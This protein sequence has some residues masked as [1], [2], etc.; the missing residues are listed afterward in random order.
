MMSAPL[1]IMIPNN[2][3]VSEWWNALLVTLCLM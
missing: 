1:D 3:F 2:R